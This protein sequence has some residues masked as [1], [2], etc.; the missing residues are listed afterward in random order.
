V[1][2]TEIIES[3]GVTKQVTVAVYSISG[4]LWVISI[5]AV[6]KTICISLTVTFPEQL[7]SIVFFIPAFGFVIHVVNIIILKLRIFIGNYFITF[8]LIVILFLLIRLLLIFLILRSFPFFKSIPG[9][10]T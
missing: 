7:V 5:P 1:V 3:S 4:T 6:I 8:I 10:I 9:V 2:K